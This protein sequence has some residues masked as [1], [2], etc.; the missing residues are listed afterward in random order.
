MFFDIV[1]AMATTLAA[2]AGAL[3]VADRGRRD[4]MTNRRPTLAYN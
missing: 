1:I 3:G 4:I 2:K